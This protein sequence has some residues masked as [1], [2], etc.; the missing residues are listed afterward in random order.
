MPAGGGAESEEEKGGGGGGSVE[1][2]GVKVVEEW[3]MGK[4]E[5]DERD[6]NSGVGVRSLGAF[7]RRHAVML[8]VAGWAE[9]PSHSLYGD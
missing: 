3:G 6:E 7:R 8:A 2:E 5:E 9:G 1:G 4:V